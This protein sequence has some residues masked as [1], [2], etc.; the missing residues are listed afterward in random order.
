M[1][2]VVERARILEEQRKE[3]IQQHIKDL[4]SSIKSCSSKSPAQ[5]YIL[6]EEETTMEDAKRISVLIAKFELDCGCSIL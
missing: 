2:P 4:E 1:H 3:R 5:A 6:G